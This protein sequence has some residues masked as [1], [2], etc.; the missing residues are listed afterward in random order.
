MDRY[1]ARRF[2]VK[3]C[4]VS[5]GYRAFEV[6]KGDT[7]NSGGAEAQIAY[8]AMHLARIGVNIE[9]LY[10]GGPHIQP[11][12]TVAGVHCLDVVPNWR[13]PTSLLRFFATLR[14]SQAS[15]F[16]ANLPDDFLFIV[17]V[18][19]S[20]RP[21]SSFIFSLSHDLHCNPWRAYHY[22][23]W[24]HNPLFA[25]ALYFADVITLQYP[26]QAAAVRPY[27][28]GELVFVP[29]LLCSV[30]G[31]PRSIHS[32]DIDI[33]WVAFI[34]PEKRLELLLDLADRFPHHRFAV[35]GG[36]D[37]LSFSENEI[38]TL[39]DRMN[40]LDNV[41]Y[42]G[43]CRHEAVLALLQRSKVLV[44]T[45]LHEGFPNTML[46][47]W[48]AGVPVLSLGIDPGGIIRREQLGLF[49]ETLPTLAA[50]LDRI[51]SNSTLNE[52]LGRRGLGYVRAQHSLET[53]CHCLDQI[54]PGVALHYHNTK[55]AL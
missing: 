12:T 27:T 46:E 17:A 6:L 54:M 1:N 36:F 35:V 13:R 21:G 41:D 22:R 32:A 50:D 26:A 20:F 5:P 49:T 51:L 47:A 39:Q 15:Y 24:F 14:G 9:L 4:F 55:G 38:K 30:S 44:N 48:G 52:E 42:H 37:P 53:L 45:S 10:G 18:A 29:Q 2:C 3:I 23:A 40:R 25:L 19:R 7:S 16:Y 11:P 34:R 33:L 28:R 8:I 31:E 43:P